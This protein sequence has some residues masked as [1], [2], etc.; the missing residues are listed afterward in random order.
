MMMKLPLAAAT[1]LTALAGTCYGQGTLYLLN[2][3]RNIYTVDPATAVATQVGIV[4]AG[5]TV[6]G[7]AYDCSTGTMYMTSTSEDALY[8]LDLNTFVATQVNTYGDTTVVMHGLE[9]HGGTNT[10][11]GGSNGSLYSIDRTSGVASLIGNAGFTSF[12]NLG[13]H[14]GNGILY[15]A[16]SANDSLYTIDPGTGAGTLIGPLNGP[17]NPHGLTYLQHLNA[18]YLVCSSTNT[19]YTVDVLTGAATPV[20]SPGSGNWLG[21]AWVPAVCTQSQFDA[22]VSLSPPPPCSVGQGGDGT[23]LANVYNAGSDPVTNATV[24]FTMPANTTFVSSSP[25]ATPVGN[26]V[27]VNL[28]TLASNTSAQ[29]SVTLTFSQQGT[30]QAQASVTISETDEVPANNNAT[31]SANVTPP[32]PPTAVASGVLTNLVSLSNSEVPG[33]PGVR[34]SATG[35]D[36][37]FRSL[38]GQR[39]VLTADTDA[40]TSEDQFLLVSDPSGVITVGA[41]ENQIG[42][43][44]ANWGLMDTVMGI[45]DS[46]HFVFTN[47]TTGATASDEVVVKWDGSQYVYV[48]AEGNAIPNQPYNWGVSI[49]S[50]T[51]QN[52]G[53]VSVQTSL[54]GA[55][56]ATDTAVFRS[57][58]NVLVA[59]EGTTIPA[60][61][62]DGATFTVRSF[63][64]GATDGQG[65]FVSADGSRTLWTGFLNDVAAQDKVVV[66][67][68]S[69]VIQEGHVLPGSGFASPVGTSV[70]YAFMETNGDWFAYGANA[71]TSDYALRNGAVIGTNAQPIH[72]GAVENWSDVSFAQLF[73]LL[74]GNNNGDY[75]IGGTT[76][77]PDLLANAVIVFNGQTVLARENDPVDA[78]GNGVFDDGVYIRTFRDDYGFINDTHF[79][80]VVTLRGSA[81]AQG[82]V[83]VDPEVGQALIRI[84]LPPS[85]PVCGTA[86]FDGDGDTGTDA[87]IE[88]F[89][90]CL[91]GNC[92]ATCFSGGA[93]FNG[94]GD[95][96]TDADIESFFRVLAGGPC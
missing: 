47:N 15:G 95:T 94:D 89:F 68:G 33:H 66:V 42:P 51:I 74:A 62:P 91:A 6:G 14:A 24:T 35:F 4:S 58:G 38:N 9:W 92:C 21:L 83:T 67:D 65:F 63:D 86:D 22:L 12:L 27:T 52:D 61:Q 7:L 50:A 48:I 19:L 55:T 88:A 46:G 10:L 56:T 40:V 43:D 31:A 82:C 25:A 29:F 2:S 8:T 79:Y 80:C 44:G 81:T 84:P 69:V 78:D 85:G 93:D 34:F 45:N 20:G 53:T 26:T 13:Y 72:T 37:P 70:A 36:R 1:L 16:S 73:F 77:A 87:D 90:A 64:T 54:I 23:F 28:G 18:L 41:R 5:G 30:A 39:F 32:I 71:D 76:D 75:V 59:Q 17:T 11:Y 49:G 60:G 96:G 57:N 3:N